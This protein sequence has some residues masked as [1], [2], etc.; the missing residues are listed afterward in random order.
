MKIDFS[1]YEKAGISSLPQVW[2]GE[3]QIAELDQIVK[4]LGL[5]GHGM[6]VY[7]DESYRVISPKPKVF[8]SVMF[9][10]EQLFSDDL[11][12]HYLRKQSVQ[13]GDFYIAIGGESIQS[14]VK[15][16]ASE[17]H[18]P[19]IA[20]PT[21]AYGMDMASGWADRCTQFGLRREQGDAPVAILVDTAYCAKAEDSITAGAIREMIDYSGK[22]A[23]TR[24]MAIAGGYSWNEDAYLIL[25]GY[26]DAALEKCNSSL[27]YGCKEAYRKLAEALIA[28]GI[29]DQEY[30]IDD[31]YPVRLNYLNERPLRDLPDG[32]FS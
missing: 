17:A 23:E 5:K 15:I 14:I 32:M 31:I 21:C 10:N 11:S 19:Y 1:A 3:N 4:S 16:V 29:F 24:A 25:N 18:M 13:E 2:I 6:A 7:D 8:R 9:D 30:P 22:L 20:C 28:C 12:L 27:R 26:M